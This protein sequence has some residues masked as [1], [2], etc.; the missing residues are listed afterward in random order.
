MLMLCGFV[1]ELIH[2]DA[3]GLK[4]EQSTGLL[5]MARD[6]EAAAQSTRYDQI[7]GYLPFP[8]HT[9]YA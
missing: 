9:V 3:L 4:Q 1:K 5:S 2:F 6:R 7:P 8:C